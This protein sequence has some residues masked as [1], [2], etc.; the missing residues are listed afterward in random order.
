LI[1]WATKGEYVLD[2]KP[3][4]FRLTLPRSLAFIELPLAKFG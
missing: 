2:R 1:S 4:A 3:C